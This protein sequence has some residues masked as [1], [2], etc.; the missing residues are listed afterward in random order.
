[1]KKLL[2][3]FLLAVPCFAQT[4]AGRAGADI[5]I[6]SPYRLCIGDEINNSCLVYDGSGTAKVNGGLNFMWPPILAAN[7]PPA[8]ANIG[9]T[10]RVTNG[11]GATDCSAGGGSFS[12]ICTSNGTTWVTLGGGGGTPGGANSSLQFNNSGAFGGL[13]LGLGQLPVGTSGAPAAQS[14]AVIDVRD[15]GAVPDGS[16]DNATAIAAAFTAANAVTTGSPI[17]YFGCNS[18]SATCEYN[19][20]GAGTSAI[21]PTIPMTIECS[22][23]NVLLNYTG[24]A[25]AVDLGPSGLAQATSQWLP[26][27]IKNCGFTG[28]A[29]YT[30]GIFVQNWITNVAILHNVFKNYGNRTGYTINAINQNYS[31]LIDG[32]N[33]DNTDGNNRNILDFHLAANAFTQF[34]NNNIACIS[35][36]GQACAVANPAV[37]LWLRDAFIDDNIM[38]GPEPLIRMSS[39]AT[40][41]GLG[42]WINHN[43]INTNN[44]SP[45]PCITFGDPG[46]AGVAMLPLYITNNVFFCPSVAG[47]PAVLGTETPSSGN[48]TISSST[49][50]GNQMSPNP[51]G[52]AVYVNTN[53]SIGLYVANNHGPGVGTALNQS[54]TPA[55]LDAGF[56]TQNSLFG[57]QSF[58]KNGGALAN[59]LAMFDANGINIIRGTFH[60]VATTLLC[61]DSSGS[62][63]AKTCTMTPANDING[64]ALT[65]AAG[66]L[67]LLNSTTQNTGAVTIAPNGGA[68]KAIVKWGGTAL[69]GG[70][71]VPGQTYAL[72]YDGTSFE[73]PILGT[74]GPFGS[75]QQGAGGPCET[76]G[77][78]T[79]LST[80][81]T[82]T[83]TGLTCL[84]ANSVIDAVVYRIT[85]TITTAA[86]FTIGD[87][88]TAA[89]FCGTQSTLTSGTTGIC[90][91]QADQTGAGGPRQTTAVAVRV[92]TNVNPG[93]GAIRLVVYY[94]TWI[95][96]T[97]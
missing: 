36:T 56:A 95:A 40:G 32:N 1:M 85:T 14:K 92:T 21:N 80:V 35:A 78:P 71:I 39:E 75:A 22:G 48:F 31:F 18:A 45:T 81:A 88:T 53:G 16:T 72:T 46:T 29:N 37:G 77:A 9:R 82:T 41:G 84:P 69:T 58:T 50:T 90:F 96:P 65:P 67:I 94:H 52:G 54:S 11:N 79:T 23:Q 47:V 20:S 66:D 28:G 62:A 44:N 86:S 27:T 17:V 38:L 34:V 33:W 97:S 3:L 15:Y 42:L 55:I 10:Y 60:R 74:A 43:T 70:E 76:A 26:Y 25:H 89:R 5:F 12:V 6:P 61:A 87:A 73:M 59:S 7:L 13:G 68:A 51:T 91:A 83:D 30:E 24:T 2:L 64:T 4:F 93:A 63:T 19:Y 8:A 57:L 49:V